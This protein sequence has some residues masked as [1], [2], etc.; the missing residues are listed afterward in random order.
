MSWIAILILVVGL[1]LVF[2]AVKLAFKLL[3]WALLL[4]GLYWL[5]APVFGWPPITF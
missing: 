5:L 1:W 3:A 2:K 4:G